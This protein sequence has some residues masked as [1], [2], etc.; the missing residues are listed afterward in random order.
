M[1]S[2]FGFSEGMSEQMLGGVL[3]YFGQDQQN[4]EN[5]QQAR[6]T[7]DFNAYQAAIN[8]DFQER[9][10]STSWQRGVGDMQAAG[11]N[12]MMAAQHGA[13]S[14]PGG[15]MA[16]GVHAIVGS[17]VAAGITA[18]KDAAQIRLTRA[19]S[20]NRELEGDMKEGPAA[21]GR[22]A[23]EAASKL[24]GVVEAARGK[25]TD[26]LEAVLGD[27]VPGIRS[28][29][30]DVMELAGGAAARADH[31]LRNL[32]DKLVSGIRSSAGAVRDAF[33]MKDYSG[34]GHVPP[35]FGRNKPMGKGR[36]KLGSAESWD[37]GP[38]NR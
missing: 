15:S 25:T 27:L 31:V 9:M 35:A 10:S 20:R 38:D 30:T 32:P 18:A 7:S 17:P 37:Y 6:W 19:E 5:V 8:R 2:A 36:G 13:A 14:T 4:R 12:P 28:S 24:P 21:L 23:G 16:S 1:P 22:Q 3:G 11:I 29:A 34:M 26:V 33:E